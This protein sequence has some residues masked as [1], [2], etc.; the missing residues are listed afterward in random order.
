MASPR[1]ETVSGTFNVPDL[2]GRFLRGVDGNAGRDPDAVNRLASKSGGNAGNA[3]GS[4]Q[5]DAFQGH[6]HLLL[7]N[8]APVNSIQFVPYLPVV[9]GTESPGG[10][11]L[12][13]KD[14][15]IGGPRENGSGIPRNSTE[16]RPINA[17]VR[18]IIKY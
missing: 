10:G 6:G 18:Y 17:N 14:L 16:T 2:R 1:T 3:V 4:S 8:D 9:G 11:S 13:V 5:T 7:I 12:P 15:K